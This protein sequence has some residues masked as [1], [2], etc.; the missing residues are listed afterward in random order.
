MNTIEILTISYFILTFILAI[1]FFFLC[2]NVFSIKKK[3]ISDESSAL[4]SLDLYYK[5]LL[6]GD[7]EKAK[8]HL[9]NFIWKEIAYYQ[10]ASTA[11]FKNRLESWEDNRKKYEI[12]FEQ[13]DATFPVMIQKDIFNFRNDFS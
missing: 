8:Q 5:Y 3:L 10:I 11:S 9:Q 2:V 6:F 1:C 12:L 4:A 7:K 13:V